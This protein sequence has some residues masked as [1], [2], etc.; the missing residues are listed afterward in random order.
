MN[1]EINAT[2]FFTLF[3]LMP[4]LFLFILLMD[5][6][7]NKEKNIDLKLQKKV[8]EIFD[9]F[10]NKKIILSKEDKIEYEYLK[11]MKLKYT[12]CTKHVV[13]KLIIICSL[14][15][16]LYKN[17]FFKKDKSIEDKKPSDVNRELKK[18]REDFICWIIVGVFVQNK[19]IFNFYLFVNQLNIETIE[20]DMFSNKCSYKNDIKETF[21]GFNLGKFTSRIINI[22]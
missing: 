12:D 1:I 6:L 10:E 17:M 19:K 11:K 9:N 21:S 15:Y 22:A 13:V 3:L 18:L 7:K 5:A 8:L 14:I 4:F 2:L 16:I 20:V